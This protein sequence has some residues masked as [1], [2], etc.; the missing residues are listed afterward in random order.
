MDSGAVPFAQTCVDAQSDPELNSVVL[1][2]I[3]ILP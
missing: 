3:S 2:K 1:R